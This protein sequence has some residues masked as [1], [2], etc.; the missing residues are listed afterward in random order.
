VLKDFNDD[1]RAFGVK[2]LRDAVMAQLGPLDI[3]N[4]AISAG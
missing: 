2:R 1:L 3:E 4:A